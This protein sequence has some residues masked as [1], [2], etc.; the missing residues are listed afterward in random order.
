MDLFG[1]I[2][3]IQDDNFNL[4]KPKTEEECD[5][6]T[7]ERI[8]EARRASE[9]EFNPL[10]NANFDRHEALHKFKKENLSKVIP[11]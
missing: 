2:G 4:K 5:L 11:K 8:L 3:D 6:E 1:D 9:K 7:I 10:K